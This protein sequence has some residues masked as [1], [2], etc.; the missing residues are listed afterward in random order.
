MHRNAGKCRNEA[1]QD[2]NVAEA[3]QELQ[4]RSEESSIELAA[5]VESG[6]LIKDRSIE[7]AA[8]QERIEGR[9]KMLC[10]AR[11]Q[12]TKK[13]YFDEEMAKAIPKKVSYQELRCCARSQLKV[14]IRTLEAELAATAKDQAEID[15]IR[16]EAR[17]DYVV[18]KSDL[19]LGRTA[20]RDWVLCLLED[21]YKRRHVV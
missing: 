8:V 1:V 15:K 18:A 9:H 12:A 13:S 4:H 6:S 21:Y 19:E 2:R 16:T 7:L 14:E 3:V 10:E 5:V 17:E 20:V 11:E